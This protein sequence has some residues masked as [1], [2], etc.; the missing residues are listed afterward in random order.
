MDILDILSCLFMVLSQKSIVAEEI[1][2]KSIKTVEISEI[3]K[4]EEYLN[5]NRVNYDSIK[6]NFTVNGK[7]CPLGCKNEFSD[8]VDTTQFELFSYLANF[9]FRDVRELIGTHL[10]SENICS[11]C[12]IKNNDIEVVLVEFIEY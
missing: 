10:D 9:C 3:L 11:R 6:I 2:V 5:D 4:L 12:F 8:S 1:Q 7:I